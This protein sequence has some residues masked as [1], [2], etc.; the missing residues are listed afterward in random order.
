MAESSGSNNTAIWVAV[1]TVIGGLLTAV[2]VNADKWMARGE[3]SAVVAPSPAA[4]PAQPLVAS[5]TPAPALTPVAASPSPA[6]TPTAPA[7]TPSEAPA[8]PVSVAGIW[9][10]DEGGRYDFELKGLLFEATQ[11]SLN[12]NFQMMIKGHVAGRDLEGTFETATG[13]T[14]NCSMRVNAAGTQINGNC[15]SDDGGWT[16]V[17]DR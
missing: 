15:V 13:E 2:V 16:F 5:P 12:G 7:P 9:R 10:S 17:L 1:I 6:A 3:K 14:G 11:T 8:A 4:T